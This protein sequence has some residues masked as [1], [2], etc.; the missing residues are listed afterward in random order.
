MG[1]HYQMVVQEYS[2][3]QLAHFIGVV[4][5]VALATLVILETAVLVV[6][7]LVLVLLVVLV[8]SVSIMGLMVKMEIIPL[9]EMLEQIQVAAAA[10]ALTSTI[11]I[12]VVMEVLVS[13]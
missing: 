7:E 10:V 3:V 2:I 8:Q 5:A 6:A 9:E 12:K 1:L 4:E 11:I 13:L